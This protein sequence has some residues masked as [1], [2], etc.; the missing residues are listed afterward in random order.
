[1]CCCGHSRSRV[2]VADDLAALRPVLASWGYHDE[3]RL[4]DDT[5][6]RL[7]G[8]RIF[9]ADVVPAITYTFGGVEVDDSGVAV[10]GSGEP[11]A[12]LFAAGADMSD[13][14]HEGYGGGLCQAVVSGRRAGRLAARVSRL[15]PTR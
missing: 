9:A 1:V 3:P 2:A 11:I 13:I 15:L 6:A 5:R 7:G 14:Y 12:G 10:D 4:D 8:G